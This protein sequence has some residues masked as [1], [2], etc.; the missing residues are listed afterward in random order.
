MNL[1]DQLNGILNDLQGVWTESILIVGAIFILI[2]GLLDSNKWLLKSCFLGVLLLAAYYNSLNESIGLLIENSLHIKPSALQFGSLFIWVG[3][4]LLSYQRSAKHLVEFCFFILA[5]LVG[6]L[7]MMKA[8]SLLI[9][10]L[11]IELASFAS[12]IL[13]NFSFKKSGF[14]A[15]IKYLL[16]GAIS[17]AFMLFG[18]GIIYGT[19]GTFFISDWGI[20][21]F[22]D[23]FS[24][25]GFVF[26]L[27]GIFFKIS[28]VPSHIWVP[29]TYQ[30]A[31]ADATAFMSIVPKLAG[32][33]LLKN[34]FDANLFVADHWIYALI[35]MLGMLTILFGTLGALRQ[36]NARRMISFGAIAH[37]GFLLPFALLA[38]DL[39]ASSF[40]Y[41]AVTYSIMNLAVFFLLD[42]YEKKDIHNVPDYAKTK[43][44]T[45]LGAAFTLI[46]ISLVGIPPLAGFTAKFFLFTTLWEGYQ[47]LA[48]GHLLWYLIIA[49]LATVASL[50][51]YL[52]IP[53]QI[54]LGQSQDTQSI[55][56]KF[57]TKILATLFCIVLLLLFFAPQLVMEA[58]QLLNNVHE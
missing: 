18:I 28:L 19:T 14:E 33:V 50:F 49:V 44:A 5:L 40:W 26:L 32:L 36:Q 58:K 29:A 37:S 57:S 3:I 42:V 9:V 10:Y 30:A 24:Q 20:A 35:L 51:F 12:Y 41:Y 16:F 11:S 17:S 4:L 56:F 25:V 23:L 43:H 6:C 34:L 47:G 45:W 39:S 48:N 7:F 54:F 38:T 53:R 8:N 1:N 2:V 27:L 21:T 52:Q 13:T 31:P 46:L 22:Q 15:G 55:K